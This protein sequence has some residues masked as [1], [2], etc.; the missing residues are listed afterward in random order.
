MACF[1]VDCDILT[2]ISVQ[3]YHRQANAPPKA[4]PHKHA[5]MRAAMVAIRTVDDIQFG[6]LTIS[7]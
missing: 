3:L 2:K 7:S 6:F 4:L 5:I 1:N